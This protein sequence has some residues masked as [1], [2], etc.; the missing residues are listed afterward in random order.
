MMSSGGSISSPTGG[1][2]MVRL[3]VTF[4]TA[5]TYQMRIE[6]GAFTLS[7][8]ASYSNPTAITQ[9]ITVTAT[10]APAVLL[11]ST[12]LAFGSQTI[13]TSSATQSVTV[14]NNGTASLDITAVT[15]AGD[16]GFTGCASPITLS[17]GASCT[18]SIF[19]F[20]TT[21]GVLAGSVSI[22]SNASGSPHVITLGGTGTPQP[23]PGIVL[24]PSSAAFGTIL[25]GQSASQVLALSN[26]GTANLD[27]SSILIVEPQPAAMRAKAVSFSQTNDCPAA[28][29]PSA[30][31]SITV[32][33]APSVA[34]SH[35]GELH[36]ISNAAPSPLVAALSGSA[37]PGTTPGL[38]LSAS[39]VTFAPQFPN[40]TSA[41][42]S[43]TLTS[44][45]TAPLVIS[46]V[47][48]SGDFSFSGC[49]P[50]TLG[51][52]ATCSFAITFRPLSEGPHSGAIVITSNAPGSPHTLSLSGTGSPRL[53]PEISLSP[54]DFAFGP[55]RTQRTVTLTSRLTNAGAAALEISQIS[56]TGSFFALSNNCPS[57]LAIGAFCDIT[58]TYAPTATGPH[59]GQLVIHSNALPSPYIA[60]LSGTGSNV[61]PPFLDVDGALDFG[62]Q[63]TGVTVRR[64]LTL[65]NTGGDPLNISQ[66]TLIGSGAFG[67]EGACASIAPERSCDL[68]VTFTPMGLAA[69]SARLDIVSNH[70]GGVVQVSLSGVGTALPRAAL[71]LSVGALGFGSQGVGSTSASQNV[72][73]TSIGAVA[74]QINSIAPSLPDFIV[75]A[76]Q[77]PAL[78][79][80]QQSCD[81]GVAFKPVASG[82]RIGFLVVQS[83]A[84]PE[85]GLPH[86]VSLIGVGCRF[87]SM[88]GSRNPQRLCAP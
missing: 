22:V 40:T 31:C 43:V 73:L 52:G 19:F 77:C 27:I 6:P 75:D 17:P 5:G 7:S 79:A 33:Y 3:Q 45:G 32:T 42:Q 74:A 71:E 51:P 16:F 70:S 50:S 20:P 54:S 12:A 23:V 24:A 53:A 81:I 47:A 34:G 72:R 9:T 62:Q 59:S 1:C 46:Q 49:G 78:L 14:T 38:Q 8:P 28:L 26:P 84:V 69:F 61:P 25:A 29:A 68:T 21:E 87:F 4:P 83:N 55:V 41:A 48:A 35:M 67:L 60:A 15:I 57:S 66:M 76:S 39:S 86:S 63:V 30:A 64:T 44:S 88:G 85:G 18:L 65:A 10:P 2:E 56:S 82:A 37:N 36:V 80:P 58:V 13:N 11:S